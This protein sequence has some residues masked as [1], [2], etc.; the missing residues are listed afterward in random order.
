MTPC[1]H[2]PTPARTRGRGG[3]TRC[4]PQCRRGA[5][6]QPQP[7]HAREL[8][9][10]GVRHAAPRPRSPRSAPSASPRTS[11]ARSRACRRATTSCAGRST[12]CGDPG[13]RSRSGR[14]PS[15]RSSGGPASPRCWCRTTR[16]SSRSAGRTTTPTS[17][18]GTTRAGTRATLAD[19]PRPELHRRARAARPRRRVVLAGPLWV[20]RTRRTG[21]TTARAR[22]SGP[23]RTSRDRG[24]C[25]R[26]R[27]GC[28]TARP[29]PPPSCCSSTSS[30]PTSRSTRPSPGP[31]ATTRTGRASC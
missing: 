16:T 21:P 6:R 11:P 7:P 17:A 14:S 25:A 22:S 26:R 29:P 12:S 28:A 1:P 24:R 9:R 13:A 3:T 4:P 30:T 20:G 31:G 15:P 18:R 19:V 8:R 2:A 27:P 23:R 5:A 10:H